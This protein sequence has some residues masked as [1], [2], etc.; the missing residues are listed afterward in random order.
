MGKAFE[1]IK[2]GLENAAALASGKSWSVEV[3]PWDSE[4]PVRVIQADNY[5]HAVKISLDLNINL[6]HSKYRTVIAPPM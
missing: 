2:A 4:K 3:L 1:K 5:E 6:D